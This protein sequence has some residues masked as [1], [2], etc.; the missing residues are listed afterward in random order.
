VAA[1]LLVLFL[2]SALRVLGNALR[3]LRPAATHA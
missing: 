1:A 2:R 3:A